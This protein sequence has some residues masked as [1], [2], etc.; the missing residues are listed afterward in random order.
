LLRFAAIAGERIEMETLAFAAQTP[1]DAVEVGLVEALDHQLLVELRDGSSTRYAFRHALTREAL[2]DDLVGPQRQRAHRRVAEALASVH[3]AD[4]DTVA[5]EIS[6]HFAKAGDA[7][8]A[9]AYALR[10][11]RR[12][13]RLHAPVA[14]GAH[15]SSALHLLDENAPERLELLLEAADATFTDQDRTAA[16]AF[17]REARRLAQERGDPVGE[18]RALRHLAQDRWR[19]GDSEGTLLIA[20]EALALVEGRDDWTEAWMLAGLIRTLAISGSHADEARDLL[21]RALEM[22]TRA[23]HAEA[24][25]HLHNSRGT[26]GA[27]E[28]EAVDAFEEAVRQARVAGIRDAEVGAL[29]N[30]GY[31][32]LWLGNLRRALDKLAEADELADQLHPG[33]D[34]YNQA[35][36]AWAQSL[37]GDLEAALATVLP[38]RATSDIPARMVALTALTEVTLR[39]G[40]WEE[41]ADYARENWTLAEANGEHQ[42]IEPALAYLARA[43]LADDPHGG[44]DVIDRFLDG[45]FRP[46]THAWGSPDLVGAQVRQGDDARLARLLEIIR[47]ITLDNGTRH[48]RAAMALCEGIAHAGKGAFAEARADLEQAITLYRGMPCPAREAEALLAL[49]DVEERAGRPAE[50]TAAARAAQ[51]IAQRLESPPLAEAAAALLGRGDADLVL[52]TVL[53]TDIVGS[54]ERAARIGDR[55]W[56]ELLE[57]H[58]AIVRRELERHRGREVDTAGDGFVAAFDSP[59]RAIRCARAAVAALRG[60]DIDIRAGLHTGECE[61]VGDKL[62]GIVVHTAARVAAAAGAG[63][64]LVSATVRDLVAGAGFEFQDRGAREL[65]GIPGE[66]RLY[67]VR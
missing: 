2:A 46:F 27:D 67:A 56:R 22:A 55:A 8:Q 45:S 31:T 12:A 52:A 6:D 58:H 43:R 7:D 51:T 4:P 25:S 57:R 20:R 53:M 29:G 64:V 50:S 15:F 36:L 63:E 39:R 32:A 40:A 65:R 26:L 18:A 16:T 24:L 60:A 61:V 14:A 44:D 11:A 42:R 37:A 19:A 28:E 33:A 30:D 62:A 13:A 47:D 59:A 34:V 41:A 66:W 17:A 9:A 35:G 3:A 21:P 23:G 1:R 38:L 54:T 48:N 10:A 49:A 5:A